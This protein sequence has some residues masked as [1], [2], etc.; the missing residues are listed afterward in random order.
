MRRLLTTSLIALVSVALPGSGSAQS[1]FATSPSLAG[2]RELGVFLSG[3]LLSTE[4]SADEGKTG[5]GGALTFATHLKSSLAFQAGI[6]GNYSRQGYSF[7]RP[8]LLTFTPT[9]SMIIQRSTA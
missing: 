2:T 9:V 5:F 1:I 7:Y 4:Y 8:P 6:S 3:R